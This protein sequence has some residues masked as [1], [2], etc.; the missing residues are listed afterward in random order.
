V[1][2]QVN[3]IPLLSP[4]VLDLVTLTLGL[5]LFLLKLDAGTSDLSYLLDSKVTTLFLV[6]VIDFVS[7]WLFSNSFF[8][9]WLQI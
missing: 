7:F 3:L 4:L 9:W 5:L 8:G 1:D 2:R 6:R